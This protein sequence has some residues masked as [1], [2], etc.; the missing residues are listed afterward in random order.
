MGFDRSNQPVWGVIE[1]DNRYGLQAVWKRVYTFR[2]PAQSCTTG[3]TV[4]ECVA[5]GA[6]ITKSLFEDLIDEYFPLEK[7]ESLVVTRKGDV[8]TAL[9]NDGGEIEP[10]MVRIRSGRK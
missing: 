2:L 7:V 9:D 4:V 1:R 3:Q 8:W 6:L 10:R 5:S